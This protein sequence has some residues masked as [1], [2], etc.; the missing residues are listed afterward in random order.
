M[1]IDVHRRTNVA[2]M[3]DGQGQA[4]ASLRFANNRTG[5]TDLEQHLAALAETEGFRSIHVAAEATNT[6]WLP[7]FDQ[8]SGSAEWEN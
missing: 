4:V 7:L 2:Q 6:Y 1:G 8:L 5:T 3:M